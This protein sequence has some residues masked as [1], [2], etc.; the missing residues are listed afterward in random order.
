[1]RAPRGSGRKRSGRGSK[2]CGP[3]G[4]RP[5][6]G[7]RPASRLWTTAMADVELHP[8]AVTEARQAR[9]WYARVS[10][11]VT[12]RFVAELDAGIAAL[13]AGPQTYS[14][15]LYGTR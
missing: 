6:R 11:R 5:C 2:T 14:P 7:R 13:G 8:L 4:S 1:M 3:G 12:A 10:Q 15:H 9:R